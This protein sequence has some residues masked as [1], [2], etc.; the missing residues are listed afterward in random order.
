[1]HFITFIFSQ[2]DTHIVLAAAGITALV[3]FG[4]TLFA[5]QTKVRQTLHNI[6]CVT[7]CLFQLVWKC[8]FYLVHT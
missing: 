5:L 4:L 8:M 6:Q 7:E 3:V 1:M 2:Y